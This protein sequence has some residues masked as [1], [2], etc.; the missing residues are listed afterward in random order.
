MNLTGI[1]KTEEQHGTET[2]LKG[3]QM[4]FKEKDKY[5]ALSLPETKN[6]PQE[7]QAYLNQGTRLR[8]RK[9]EGTKTT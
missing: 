7:I 3:D 6:N 8:E 5:W 9:Q 1:T 4:C 2:T